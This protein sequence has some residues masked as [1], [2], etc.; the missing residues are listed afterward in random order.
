MDKRELWF[1]RPLISF[2][3]VRLCVR[4]HE[5]LHE[6]NRSATVGHSIGHFNF[7]F[8]CDGFFLEVMVTAESGL[9]LERG[10][11]VADKQPSSCDLVFV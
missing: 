10:A 8:G 11:T 7:F 9:I 2:T 4:T 1:G 5:R 3:E 6:K